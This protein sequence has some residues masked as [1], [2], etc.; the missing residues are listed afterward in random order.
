[1]HQNLQKW[2]FPS[3][4]IHAKI[5]EKYKD[6]V[7]FP[8]DFM[9]KLERH[10]DPPVT[11]SLGARAYRTSKRVQERG[12]HKFT[13]KTAPL[14]NGD[15]ARAI[16]A[17]D[18]TKLGLH[19]NYAHAITLGYAKETY[20]LILVVDGIDFVWGQTCTTRS[21]PEDLIQEFLTMTNLKVSSVRFDGA[22]EFGK[23][24]S[25]KAYCHNTE[26]ICY[27]DRC[28]LHSYPKHTS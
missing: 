28:S 14:S 20:Y 12:I 4:N 11:V 18:P 27:G 24:H 2:C 9:W 6:Q 1:M 13:S 23:S 5:F 8:K 10:K 21:S 26:E 25:F 17:Q 15:I 19:I 3:K 22:Q 16:T 7:G